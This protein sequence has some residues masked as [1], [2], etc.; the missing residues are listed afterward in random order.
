MV[1]TRLSHLHRFQVWDQHLL[2]HIPESRV[3]KINRLTYDILDLLE[4]ELSGNE[5]VRRL[6]PAGY[7]PEEVAQH[8]KTLIRMGIL[9]AREEHR[10]TPPENPPLDTLDLQVSH[11]CNLDC[12]Y[13]YAQGGNFGGKD[14]LMSE[15]TARKAIDYF[16]AHSNGEDELCISFDGGEPLINFDVIRRT[17]AYARQRENGGSRRF[18]FNIGT[19][20]TLVTENIASFFARYGFSPQVSLDGDQPVHDELRPFKNGR[21]SYRE[22]HEGIRLFKE[23][24]VLLASRITLTPRNLRLRDSVELLHKLGAIR[25]AAFPATGIPGDYAFSAEHL[26]ILKQEYDKTAEYFLHTLFETGRFVCF[27]NFTDN[28]KNLHHAK[29]LHYGCGAARTFISVDPHEDIYPCHRLV[30]NKKYLMGNLKQG[31]DHGKRRVFLENHSGAKEKCRECWARNLCG[32]GCLVEAEYHNH[33][34]KIPF[35]LSC[36]IYKYEKELSMMIYSRIFS[37]NKS[38]L[39]GMP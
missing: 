27:S 7:S 4:E 2:L 28:I 9:E 38:I 36:E 22:L 16:L 18:R 25:I 23:K 3:Y 30:G 31:I 5:I 26:D 33:D 11:L 35:D 37:W 14:A 21:G 15:D 6:I 39:D 20:A 1:N 12:K 24:G 8:L 29:I 10:F 19:N 17:A 32:G 34:I 13:C